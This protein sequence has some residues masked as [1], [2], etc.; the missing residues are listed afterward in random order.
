MSIDLSNE[1]FENKPQKSYPVEG[2]HVTEI[3]SF[4]LENAK[5]GNPVI[6]AVFLQKDVEGTPEHIEKFPASDKVKPGK[7]M[8]P[9]DMS[10]SK[11]IKIINAIENNDEAH[12]KYQ[13]SNLEQ[14]VDMLNSSITGKEY[15]QK[16]S[17]EQILSSKGN[18]FVKTRIPFSYD[19]I[20]ENL[21]VS[22]S[23]S[24]L[25]FNKDN[26]YDFIFYK[27]ISINDIQSPLNMEDLGSQEIKNDL[28]F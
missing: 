24:K 12:K 7:K 21:Y 3:L 23:D 10:L 26:K 5:N 8:S 9:L 17:G 22:P 4:S 16:F 2:I 1:K 18:L 19:K 25:T 28:P 11:L 20:A 6:S 13:A 14:F 15:K 27:N